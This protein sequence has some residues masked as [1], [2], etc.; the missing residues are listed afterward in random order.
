[1]CGGCE[2]GRGGGGEGKV[3]RGECEDCGRDA[4]DW[5]MIAKRIVL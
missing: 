3:F 2:N 1:M 5:D 4:V